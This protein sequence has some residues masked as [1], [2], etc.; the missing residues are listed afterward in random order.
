KIVP[1]PLKREFGFLYLRALRTGSRAL[2]LERGS[3][4]DIILRTKGIRTALWA[5][6]IAKL[7]AMDV[8]ADAPEIA[9]VL[10]DIEKRLSRYIALEAPG[11]ATSLHVSELTRDHLRKTMAFFLQLSPDQDRVPF[12]HAG[13]GTLNT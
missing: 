11:N 12:A 2:S 13:T 5:K 4:L 7:R 1:R 9:P 10:R 3:L 8:E 6:T